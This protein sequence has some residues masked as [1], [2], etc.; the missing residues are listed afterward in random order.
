MSDAS[1]PPAAP[2]APPAP[3]GAAEA[4]ARILD[5]IPRMSVESIPLT[6]AGEHVLAES[7]RAKGLFETALP[8]RWYLPAEDVRTELLEASETRTRCAYKGSASYWNARVGGRLVEDLVWSYADPEHEAERVR[9]L[10]CFFNE[11]VDLELDGEAVER[12]RTQWSR[13]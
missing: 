10:L 8:P 9:G 11:L 12:P 3:I 5:A 13:D 1:V 7:V 4:S 6:M 2:A